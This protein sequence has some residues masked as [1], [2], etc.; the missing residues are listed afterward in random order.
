[1]NELIG[2]E[3]LP[4][5][6]IEKISIDELIDRYVFRINLAMYDYSIKDERLWFEKSFS[7]NVA[8]K[9][10]FIDDLIESSFLKSG[11]KSIFDTN[12]EAS[13]TIS[14]TEGVQDLNTFLISGTLTKINYTANYT[15]H[16]ESEVLALG[17]A[18]RYK[19]INNLDIYA[20]SVLVFN[21]FSTNRSF[22]KYCGP[23]VGE[24][25]FTG[26]QLNKLTKY[27]YDPETNQEY[28]GPVHLHSSGR[29]MEG[30][31][32]SQTPHKFLRMVEEENYKIIFNSLVGESRLI[33]AKTQTA[34]GSSPDR[35][36]YVD[37]GDDESGNQSGVNIEETNVSTSPP[38]EIY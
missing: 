38:T 32:H 29:Y 24:T 18:I 23:T 9:V 27:F 12:P 6:Y 4:N 16:K 25:V 15:I 28:A 19:K 17:G 3:N 36:G 5:V 14:L 35:P 26:G 22:N 30:S 13:V 31:K 1:M 2:K 34:P 11:A 20:S 21:G 7:S 10:S 37:P 33:N 8:I